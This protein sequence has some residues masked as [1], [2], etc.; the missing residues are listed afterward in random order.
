LWP[1]LVAQLRARPTAAQTVAPAP[2]RDTRVPVRD[3]AV[4][5]PVDVYYYDHL[6]ET[7]GLGADTTTALASRGDRLAYETLNLVDGRRT[8]EGIRDVI[9]GRYEPVPVR[10]IADYLAL[11]ARAGVVRWTAQ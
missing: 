9:A 6:R 4:R 2:D 11:L 8:V 1:V 10:E 5:G 7:L 3:P